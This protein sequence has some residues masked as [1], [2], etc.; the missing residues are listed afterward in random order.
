MWFLRQVQRIGVPEDVFHLNL[1]VFM[2]KI[3]KLDQSITKEGIKS[4][5]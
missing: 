2:G 1:P 3:Q 4:P 5:I